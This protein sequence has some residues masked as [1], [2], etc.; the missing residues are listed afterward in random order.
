MKQY[1]QNTSGIHDSIHPGDHFGSALSTGN[2]N[3]TG[4]DDLVISA[5]DED[6]NSQTSSGVVHVLYGA[7]TTTTQFWH[8]NRSGIPDSPEVLDRF[9]HVLSP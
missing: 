1:H 6:Y 3:G 4:I 7:A 8:Q 9:G 2:F 5:E